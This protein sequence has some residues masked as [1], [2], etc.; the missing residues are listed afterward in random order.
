MGCV[1]SVSLICKRER[2]PMRVWAVRICQQLNQT[3]ATNKD[4]KRC[5]NDDTSPFEVSPPKC[6]RRACPEHLAVYV[7]FLG[8]DDRNGQE[9]SQSHIDCNSR[10]EVSEKLR[11]S[12]VSNR[13]E[14]EVRNKSIRFVQRMRQATQRLS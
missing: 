1:G 5:R 14:L 7:F 11:Y 2:L 6:I 9:R 4:G 3:A 8:R 10:N 13:S 12:G